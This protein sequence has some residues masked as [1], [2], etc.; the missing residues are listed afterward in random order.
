MKLGLINS[1]WLGS[2]V[3]TAEGIRLTR[4]I[5]FDTIDIQVEPFDCTASERR[6]IRETCAD[7]EL[8]IISL[9]CCALGLADFNRPVR[10][11]HI[12]RAR[13]VLD[14]AYDFRAQNMLLVVGEYVWQ[15]EVIPARDQWRWAVDGV[16]ALG[17]HA[18][19]LGLEI[20]L[21][22][23]PFPSSI[24][25]SAALMKQFLDEVGHQTVKA[26]LDISHLALVHDPAD[27]VSSL[28]GRI[29]HVHLSDCDGHRHGDLPPG[30]GVVDFPP[31]L[32]ALQE[33]GFGGVVS[34]E[35][36]YAP[37][38]SLIVEWVREAYASTSALMA[39]LGLRRAS[40]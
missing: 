20:A 39:G 19:T 27:T 22:L 32:R 31:Y 18:A 12:Q 1:A 16:R 28:Q 3:G 30:R 25:S 6:L 33:S 9:P 14:I 17:D 8:P 24:I 10:Q 37:D 2:P 35:L 15:Q 38:P 40:A 23:E 29:A 21:E 4:E 13:A 7:V 26:N 11:F 5:G 36:E 34:I